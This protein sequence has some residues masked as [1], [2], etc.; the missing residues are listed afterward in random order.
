MNNGKYLN[1]NGGIGY[2][3]DCVFNLECLYCDGWGEMSYIV[4]DMNMFLNVCFFIKG[5]KI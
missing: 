3:K 5:L 1:G 4:K 2:I